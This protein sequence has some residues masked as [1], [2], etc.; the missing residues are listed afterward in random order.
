MKNQSSSFENILV[1]GLGISG[2]A[3]VSLA[4]KLGSNVTAIDEKNS[5][6]LAKY[7]R[8]LSKNRRLKIILGWKGGRLPASDLTVIVISPGIST[9]SPMGKSASASG[10]PVISELEFGARHCRT[11]II[12]ITGTNGKTTTT[13]LTCHLLNSIGVKAETAG[14]IGV[15]LSRAIL[16]RKQPDFYV[17]EASSFQLD[18]CSTFK[19]LTAAI[20]NITS[21]HMN[22]Y[23]T[24]DDYA[25]SKFSVFRNID[26]AEKKIIR[27][28]LLKYWRKFNTGR[29]SR[30]GPVIFSS[31]KSDSDY[32]FDGKDIFIKGRKFMDISETRLLGTHNAENLLASLALVLA[33]IPDASRERLRKGAKNF[34]TGPH[35]LEIVLRKNGITC[36]NDSKAT[37][38]D[39]TVVALKAVGGRKNVCLIAG[40][41]DKNMDFT[42][43]LA[44][45]NRIKA[46]FLVGEC[47]K[48]LANLWKN[49][50]SCV[51]F[52]SFEDA[53]L[54]ACGK[55]GRGD[56][57]LLAPG[58]ASMDMF[59]DYKDRGQKFTFIINRRFESEK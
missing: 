13:E 59:K 46:A 47:K 30:P 15:P 56:V 40:G 19:P 1:L 33:V 24:E 23:R 50:I 41:L 57:V 52:N 36:I 8:S 17:V 18:A 3:A 12:A 31:E 5:P 16:A 51:I 35:R 26:S 14:N 54:A 43:V 21:D 38:P 34:R 32:Y 55:A 39:S 11:P 6:E 29:P 25:A 44:E 37:N 45:K 20:L 9:T 48:K 49:D 42:P 28:D 58:C 4:L 22:R 10:I 27:S 2:R 53:V 7:K